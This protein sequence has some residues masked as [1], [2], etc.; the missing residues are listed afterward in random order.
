MELQTTN[1][2][3]GWV[4]TRYQ[5]TDERPLDVDILLPDFLP[6]I[7]AV[8]KC[9]VTPVV[10][11]RQISGDRVLADGTAY[12]QVWYLDEERRCVRTFET[13]QPFSSSFTVAGM[14]SRDTVILTAKSHYINCRATGPRRLDIHGA[15]GVHLTVV[16]MKETDVLSEVCGEGIHRRC[17]TITTSV[18]C[19]AAD[20]TFT[21]N[22]TFE[23]AGEMPAEW[24]MRNEAVALVSECKQLPG[25]AVA[26]GEICLKTVYATDMAG[27]VQMVENRVPFSQIIDA[28]GITETSVCDC[29]A[30]VSSCDVR[31]S[32]NPNGEMRLLSVSIKIALSLRCYA[33]DCM[34]IVCDAFHTAYPA[35]LTTAALKPCHFRD[36]YHE[37]VDVTH[38][39]TLPD[40]AV[41]E[42]LDAWCTVVGLTDNH[43]GLLVS[44]L[45]RDRDGIVSY[46][47]R[48]CEVTVEETVANEYLSIQPLPTVCTCNKENLTVRIRLHLCGCVGE[49]PDLTAVTAVELNEESP[50]PG[51]ACQVKACFANAG[52]EVWELARRHHASPEAL[53]A[54]NDLTDDV[55]AKRTMLLIPLS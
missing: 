39:V 6:E 40:A 30:V 15:F 14:D 51:T 48:P 54:E 53:K 1:R 36:M 38:E 16:G 4:C 33:T 29:R 5:E 26:K 25:K 8:L 32:A 11:A 41:E 28:D 3:M 52:D 55:I 47:E 50:Y 9:T 46:Y 35:K 18:P 2:R 19:A 10:Q 22:E 42:V 27:G 23:L 34:S 12:L 31:L 45:T 17:Q 43:I 49:Y 13:S 37:T 20:K 24:L 44:L 7:A 21:I